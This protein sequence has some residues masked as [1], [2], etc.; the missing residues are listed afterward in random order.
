MSTAEY[1]GFVLDEAPPSSD[2]SDSSTGED[3]NGMDGERVYPFGRSDDSD[4]SAG[5]DPDG[6]DGE[7]FVP[8][9]DD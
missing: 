8:W 9:A 1:D 3:P 4:S 7:R 6:M 5:D 2:D